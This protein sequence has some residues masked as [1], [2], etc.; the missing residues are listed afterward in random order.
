MDVATGEGLFVA[1]VPRNK[2]LTSTFEGLCGA[3][4]EL[5]VDGPEAVEAAEEIDCVTP[6]AVESVLASMEPKE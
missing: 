1:L 6:F 4:V 2:A 3:G 5:V